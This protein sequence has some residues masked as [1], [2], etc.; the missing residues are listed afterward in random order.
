MTRDYVAI[1]DGAKEILGYHTIN[2]GMMNMEVLIK[3]PA[4]AP[5]HGELPILFLGQVAVG[6]GAQGQGICSILMHHVFQKACKVSDKAG[7][8]AMVV[9]VMSDGGEEDFQRR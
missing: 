2:L 3:E 4:G 1:I 9:D 6:L 5:S 7:C 8:F